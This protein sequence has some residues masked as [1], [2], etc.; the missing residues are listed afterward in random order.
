[1]FVSNTHTLITFMGLCC[2]SSNR[3]GRQ[4]GF[5]R[6]PLLGGDDE[7]DGYNA[8]QHS[9]SNDLRDSELEAFESDMLNGNGDCRITMIDFESLTLGPRIGGGAEGIVYKGTWGRSGK[10]PV[11]IKEMG[12]YEQRGHEQRAKLAKFKHEASI[13]ATL[14]HPNI[15]TFY[16]VS[17]H[18][19]DSGNERLGSLGVKNRLTA[20]SLGLGDSVVRTANSLAGQRRGGFT[21]EEGAPAGLARE[22]SGVAGHV[23]CYLVTELCRNSLDNHELRAVLRRDRTGKLW[24]VVSQIVCGMAYLHE[25][26][27]CH[28]DLKR[29]NILLD[30][31][32]R[33]VKIC[34]FGLSSILKRD[35]Q[36][37]SV[38]VGTPAY[39]APELIVSN[40]DT[41]LEFSLAIDVF[42]FGVLLWALWCNENPYQRELEEQ[43]LNSYTLLERIASG[44]RPTCSA[45]MPKSLA[46]VIH[47]CW[48][49]ENDRRP[50]FAALVERLEADHSG[51]GLLDKSAQK[52]MLRQRKGV[53]SSSG[54]Q[55]AP[56]S[57]PGPNLSL[58]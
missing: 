32:W 36:S 48:Q 11:A 14:R 18:A 37:M 49:H 42:S 22:G 27:I 44:M 57:I 26:G 55:S 7:Q 34:D 10:F 58:Q 41:R 15:V 23:H 39:M 17:M 46:T 56:I 40:L 9:R 28:R 25:N 24:S 19:P 54:T 38:M 1:M 52:A 5:L 2:S 33:T 4:F 13:L 31:A 8:Q 20:T 6:T 29:Q 16:G 12:K 51:W 50:T 43:N 3:P 35:A 47:A 45:D 21:S 30:D 53:V